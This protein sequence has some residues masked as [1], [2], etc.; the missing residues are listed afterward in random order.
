MLGVSKRSG[1]GWRILVVWLTVCGLDVCRGADRRV[2]FAREVLPILHRSCF[3]CHGAQKQEGD[4][5]LDR[6]EDVLVSGMVVAGEPEQSELLRRISLPKGHDE[7]MPAVGETLPP[8]K[9]AVIRRWIEQGADWP[10]N[11]TVGQHWAYVAP[12]RPQLPTVSNPE[13]CRKPIDYF[14]LQRLD[15][16][17]LTPSPR[18]DPE[19]L[20]RRLFLDL[21]GL[22]PTP[23]EVQAFVSDPSNARLD[24]LVDDLLQRPQFGERWARPWLDLARYADSHGFQRDNLWDVWAYRDWVIQAFNDDMP[25][26][27]F[28]IEQLAGDLLPNATES[29]KV[30]TGFH[31][32]TPTNVE[33]GSIPEETRSEQILDRVNTTGAVWLG[34]TLECCQCHDHKYDPFTARDYYRL[35]A[36][37]NSTALEADRTNPKL[38]SSIQ[39]Q[40]PTMPLSDSNRDAQ[41]TELQSQLA[42]F[43][44]QQQDRRG[45]LEKTLEAWAEGNAGLL[46]A[47][48]QIHPLKV[49]GFRS[50]GT[51]DGH[52]VLDDGSVLLVGGDPPEKD[53]Y[54]VTIDCQELR[55]VRAIRLDALRHNSLPGGGPGRG[56]P[57][58]RNFVLNSLTVE[59]V[60]LP[61][62][63]GR[64]DHHTRPLRFVSAS[65]SFSQKNRDAIGA[66]DGQAKSGWAISPQFNRSHW[67]TFVLAEPLD[68]P[69]GGQLNVTMSQQYGQS[70][71]I[72][73]FRLSAVTGQPN[74][75]TI[76]EAVT[77]AA[78]KPPGKWTRQDRSAL[79]NY[80]VQQDRASQRLANSVSK[81]EQQLAAQTPD[82]TLVM[83]ELDSP[84]MS[85]IFERGD[86]KKPGPAVEPGTPAVLPA[87]P[88]GPQNRLTLA[89]WLVAADN[90]L[91]SRVT[92]NRWWAEL[93]G[94]GLVSTVEDFG[95]KGE[96]PTHPELLDWLAVEFVEQGW[97]LKSL[98]KTIVQSATY[99]QSSHV[100]P[101]LQER[102]DLNRWLARGPR[103][104]M[105]AEMIRDNALEASGLLSLK[106]FGPSIHPYQPNGIWSKVG[107]NSYSYEVSP[108]EDQYRRGIY[109]VLK[110]G[111]P[112]PS[113]INFDATARLAC[114]VKRS[115]T[116]TP[117]QA[118]TLLNDP[119][120]VEAAQALAERVLRDKSGRSW[121]E[122][123]DYAFQLCTARHPTDSERK[124]LAELFRT[125]RAVALAETQPADRLSAE[126]DA[127]KAV[128]TTVLNLHET[129]TK[130]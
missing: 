128:A 117:L 63:G 49:T 53:I 7:V 95:L 120:F 93:F 22:P 109:V 90:P 42:A 76:P 38:P 50:E 36:Y 16:E 89:R 61:G 86:Y 59:V 51:T 65:A 19:K 69:A 105:D 81:L 23:A 46:A 56:D 121:D 84:R 77:T 129:V 72:G 64:S 13:W 44:Q 80:C 52:E 123:L 62:D 14:V 37:F 130:D 29:Q 41:R 39:F 4:L 82:T 127:W 60:N 113:F 71:T 98:L 8:R 24:A 110:R 34:T 91:T 126:V 106:Q 112:Y 55:G 20:V 119:V 73:C 68:L 107:G 104:R 54:T 124:V 88:D 12:Q 25:F 70:R 17:G 48:P 47:Q 115:R 66:V 27:Q 125:Q 102:D 103:F 31:R 116:N 30:A 40:G 10:A 43:K 100:T 92:V 11:A 28:T 45:E 101:E 99:Q 114:T 67:A 3:E 33:A 57:V 26:D 5:R 97:S 74:G 18:A 79:V 118:L 78:S 21:I 75:D 35:F 83:V 108:G 85:T 111:S 122:Q 32:C 58:R 87:A 6:R 9:I 1:L 94:R 96:P 15:A 2:D